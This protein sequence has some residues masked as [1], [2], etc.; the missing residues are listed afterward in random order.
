M[1]GDLGRLQPI[2]DI[3]TFDFEANLEKSNLVMIGQ[4][5]QIISEDKEVILNI[6]MEDENHHRIIYL[7]HVGD[8]VHL[9]HSQ[10]Y[11]KLIHFKIQIIIGKWKL[12]IQI[13][14]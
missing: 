8:Q 7:K 4:A 10:A 14:I 6:Q 12:A 5:C 2:K 9:M 13:E 11:V 1:Q 3:G